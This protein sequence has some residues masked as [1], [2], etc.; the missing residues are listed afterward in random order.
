MNLHSNART[1]PKSRFE[2]VL[3]S[4]TCSAEQVAA[5]FAV[6]SRT[7]R[8]WRRR[9]AVAG[10]DGLV[11]RSSRPHRNA[12]R[13]DEPRSELI[14]QLRLCRLTGPQIAGALKMPRSTVAAVLK[15]SGMQ[16]LRDLEPRRPVIR[17]ERA[18]PGELIHVDTKKLGRIHGV[19]HRITGN[20]Q[21][22]TRGVGWEFA[23]VAIDDAS[24][25]AYVEVLPD[26][27]PDTAVGFLYRALA[28][29]RRHGL[30]VHQLMSDNGNAYLSHAFAA[31]CQRFR[32]RHLRTQPYTPRTN[33]KAERLIQTLLREWAYAIP[34]ASSRARTAA[35]TR[36]L[37]YY[38]RHRPHAGIGST[39]P[40][41]RLR[42][43][44]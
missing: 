34:Y 32:I 19:G 27:H 16:R 7:V 30:T 36:W 5:D 42:A 23:H 38:N 39:T 28:F 20:R 10:R 9:F 1:T 43:L 18:V 2:L 14:R 17:Y 44:R 6:S 3:R 29:Y 4:A 11:D 41:S 31:A 15:R 40:Y 13:T 26:E 24:R 21:D 35:L 8:K 25:L 22:G 12:W 37:G 33:G